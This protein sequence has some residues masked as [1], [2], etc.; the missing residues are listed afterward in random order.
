[1][2]SRSPTDEC[3]PGHENALRNTM[4]PILSLLCKYYS[5][6]LKVLFL[7]CA[8]FGGK[9]MFTAM[10]SFLPHTAVS[11]FLMI[12]KNVYHSPDPCSSVGR[13]PTKRKVAGSIPCQGTCLGFGFSPRQ[14]AYT[15]KRQPTDVSLPLSSSLPAPLSKNK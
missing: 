8:T 4:N 7:T 3:F 1:M 9:K 14:D 13:R 12:M 2:L 5:N 10:T 6:K 11:L 15:Y